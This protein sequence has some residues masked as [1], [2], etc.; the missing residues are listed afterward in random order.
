MVIG[1]RWQGKLQ[2]LE[3]QAFDLL[4]RQQPIIGRDKRLVV[5]SITQEDINHLKQPDNE[6]DRTLRSLSDRTLDRLVGILEKHQPRVIGLDLFRPGDVDG[7]KYPNLEASLKQGDLVTVCNPPSEFDEREI[8]APQSSHKK[9]IGFASVLLDEDDVIRRHLMLRRVKDKKFCKKINNVPSFSL[10]LA[11]SYL[12]KKGITRQDRPEDDFLKLG[13]VRLPPFNPHSGGYH[14]D[15][16]L[17]KTFQIVIN[18]R[19]YSEH[20]DIAKIISVK[21]LLD[22]PEIAQEAKNK[23]VLIGRTDS[24]NDK[25]KTP[26]TTEHYEKLPGVL[27][28]AQIVSQI[29]DAVENK[30]PLIW[31]WPWWGDALWIWCWSFTGGAIAWTFHL[32]RSRQFQSLLTLVFSGVVTFIILHGLCWYCLKQGVW[33]PLVPSR[34]ALLIPIMTSFLKAIIA[35]LKSLSKH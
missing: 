13:E 9:N 34:L 24:V 22:N 15:L 2:T 32:K 19:P 10:R 33:I 28:H 20:E 23:I 6:T 5:V 4:M 31:N 35:P 17:H 27:V 21:N 30:R 12:Q 8:A 7:R 3:L 11:L 1:M 26:Y 25:Y 14:K 16:K 18:Y 29:I